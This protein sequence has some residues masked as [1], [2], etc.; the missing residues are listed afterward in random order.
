MAKDRTREYV[1]LGAMLTV[2]PI[3]FSIL[4][5]CLRKRRRAA[6]M[7]KTDAMAVGSGGGEVLDGGEA[8]KETAGGTREE[9]VR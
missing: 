8:G 6:Q 7:S 5:A 1:M 2:L 3:G 4:V 9:A